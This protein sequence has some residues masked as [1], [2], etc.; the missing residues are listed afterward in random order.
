MVVLEV[1]SQR[2]TEITTRANLAA[3]GRA[4]LASADAQLRPISGLAEQIQ[5]IGLAKVDAQFQRLGQSVS[6]VRGDILA[7]AKAGGNNVN[8]LKCTKS[9][10]RKLLEMV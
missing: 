2:A 7:A 1:F 5:Q 8:A 3:S 10:I 4:F 9:S 6:K